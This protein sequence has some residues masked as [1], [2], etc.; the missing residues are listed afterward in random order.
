MASA[1][2]TKVVLITGCSSGIGLAACI[3]FAKSGFMVAAT[4]RR[5]ADID[6]LVNL[7]IQENLGDK[8]FPFILDTTDEKGAHSVVQQVISRFGHIDVLVNNAGLFTYGP[9]ETIGSADFH[10]IFDAN[11]LGPVLVAQA[12]LPSMRA[13]KHGRIINVGSVSGIVPNWYLGLYSA[14]KFALEGLTQTLQQEIINFGLHAILIVPG[15]TNTQIFT[16]AAAQT[17]PVPEDYASG[18]E[19][20]GASLP[21]DIE[22][23]STAQEVAAVIFK[24]ASQEKPEFRYY[25]KSE[26]EDMIAKVLKDPLHIANP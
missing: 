10:R 22:E 17:R 26:H 15:W 12:V 7:A 6:A 8:V 2:S 25:V 9:I 19:M 11:V 20:V 1:S 16:K 21:F 14:S 18:L 3:Q 23:G 24:A 4:V 13:R 5:Q